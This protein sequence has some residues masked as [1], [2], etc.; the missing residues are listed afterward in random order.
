[1]AGR[2]LLSFGFTVL[3]RDKF[4]SPRISL[5]LNG[6]LINIVAQSGNLAVLFTCVSQISVP[7][8][9][10][11][12]SSTYLLSSPLLQLFSLLVT[13]SSLVLSP[14]H[15]PYCWEGKLSLMNYQCSHWS[16][17]AKNGVRCLFHYPLPPTCEMCF[18]TAEV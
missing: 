3:Q 1:M 14:V 4:S 12:H 18:V 2:S 7:Q 6:P 5:S 15:L 13:T 10:C 16:S 8:S 17:H 9:H 11:L